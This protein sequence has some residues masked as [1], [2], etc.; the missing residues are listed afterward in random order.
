MLST[1]ARRIMKQ[2]IMFQELLNRM[3]VEAERRV[4]GREGIKNT[5]LTRVMTELNLII[6]ESNNNTQPNLHINTQH[7]IHM[8]MQLLLEQGDN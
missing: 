3:K 5:D 7:E 4:K 2:N 6:E 8:N 1:Q